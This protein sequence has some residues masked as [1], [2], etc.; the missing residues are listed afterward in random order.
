MSKS[1]ANLIK[2]FS[3]LIAATATFA[4]SAGQVVRTRSSRHGHLPARGNHA[5]VA[6]KTHLPRLFSFPEPPLVSS[7]MALDAAKGERH[8]AGVGWS[9]STNDADFLAAP[10]VDQIRRISC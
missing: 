3:P 4:L 6:R 8:D 1:C 7:C 9:P 5:A 2:V 10:F